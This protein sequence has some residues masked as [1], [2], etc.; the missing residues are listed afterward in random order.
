M[1]FIIALVLF[2]FIAYAS[3]NP[4][5]PEMPQESDPE[6]NSELVDEAFFNT[7][8]KA[9]CTISW[10]KTQCGKI[11]VKPFD[12]YCISYYTCRCVKYF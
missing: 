2:S 4:V 1:R 12:A 8:A 10:C 5:N 6:L 3:S 7:K 11:F 9:G